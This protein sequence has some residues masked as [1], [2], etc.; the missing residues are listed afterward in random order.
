MQ[1]KATAVWHGDVKSDEGSL[2][3]ESRVLD[4][5]QYSFSTRFENASEP[6][7]KNCWLLRLLD[8]TRWHFP[9]SSG[10]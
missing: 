5:T 2:S 9:R 1:R 3:T 10:W 7:L 6:T 4:K 8:D